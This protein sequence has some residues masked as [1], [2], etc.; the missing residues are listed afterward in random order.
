MIEEIAV[1]MGCNPSLQDPGLCVVNTI[2][3]LPGVFGLFFVLILYFIAIPMLVWYMIANMIRLT[4]EKFSR[5][6]S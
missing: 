5:G 4:R 6:R 3:I 2:L 1:S